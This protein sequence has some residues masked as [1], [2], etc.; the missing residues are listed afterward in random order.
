[1]NVIY[2][3][4]GGVI[5]PHVAHILK[6]YYYDTDVP[7]SFWDMDTDEVFH[8]PECPH[9]D[10]VREVFKALDFS[11]VEMAKE[12][13][14]T[15]TRHKHYHYFLAPAFHE[16]HLKGWLLAG[17]VLYAKK[18]RLR[19]EKTL[20][21]AVVKEPP[22]QVYLCQLLHHLLKQGVHIGPNEVLSRAYTYMSASDMAMEMT[23]ASMMDKVHLM[24]QDLLKGQIEDALKK[25]QKTLMVGEFTNYESD[26]ALMMLRQSLCALEALLS[27]ELLKSGV[28]VWRFMPI[29]NEVFHLMFHH[30][31]FNALVLCGEEII[32]RYGQLIVGA[33]NR[34]EGFSEPVLKAQAYIKR[35]FKEKIT[36]EAICKAANLSRSGLSMRFKQEVG[37]TLLGAIKKVRVDY[38]KHLMENESLSFFDIA[39]ECGFENQNYFSTVFKEVTGV[40]PSTYKINA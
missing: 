39:L 36:V 11:E 24:V 2:A 10:E 19:A 20:A 3:A 25:Y 16:N 22:R 1:M 35:H 14:F 13:T 28:E 6:S 15:V 32:H 27:Q 23:Y 18:D 26:H 17:P 38:A 5:A 4:N 30:N 31:D 9:E 8:Y 34:A 21:R 12:Q 37:D 7:A 29:K 33:D 40:S